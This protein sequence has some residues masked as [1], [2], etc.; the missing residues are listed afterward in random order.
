[1]ELGALLSW[2]GE[3]GAVIAILCGGLGLFICAPFALDRRRR[4]AQWWGL[5]GAQ[6]LEVAQRRYG[7]DP[8]TLLAPPPTRL[9]RVAYWLGQRIRIRQRKAPVRK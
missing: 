3:F 7:A 6:W 8:T 4:A 2:K 9:E 5:Y 1:M